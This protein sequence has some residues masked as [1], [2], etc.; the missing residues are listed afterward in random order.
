MPIYKNLDLCYTISEPIVL[1]F[2]KFGKLRGNH[3]EVIIMKQTSGKLSLKRVLITGG[4][5]TLGL[6]VLLAGMIACGKKNPPDTTATTANNGSDDPVIVAGGPYFS[7]SAIA[8]SEDG[9]WIYVGG[10]T[11]EAIYRYSAADYALNAVYRTDSPV[12]SLTVSG[13]KVYVGMGKLGGKLTV[14][15]SDLKEEGSVVVGHTPND[16]VISGTVAYVANRFSCTVS[17]VDL[18]TM[19]ETKEIA[20]SREPMAMTLVGNK[21]Y[22]A[23]HLPEDNAVADS[24]SPRISVIDT[25]KNEVVNSIALCNGAANVKDII[26]S[27]DGKTLYVSHSIARYTYP[28]TQLDGGW[29]YTNGI[30]VID[31][32]SDKASYAFLLDDVELGAGNPW[33]L[34]I[35]EKGTALYVAISGS[36]ELMKVDLSALAK[37]V[38]RVGTGNGLVASK[39]DIVDYIPFA[40]NCKSR[41]NLGG[42][43]VRSIA[44]SGD[45]V[46]CAQYFSG[47]ITAVGVS[48]SKMKVLDAFALGTQPEADTIRLGEALWYDSTICYQN[49]QS[50]ASCHPDG[51][52]DGY[53]WD[54]LNDGL[55]VSKQAKSMLYAMRTPPVMVTGI[56]PDGETAV[57]AG[58]K[59]ICFNADTQGIV[60]NINAYLM[61]MLPEQSP[62]LNDD[63]TLTE[64]ATRGKALFEQYGCVICH[65]APLYTDMKTHTSID[66]ENEPSWE[67]RDMDTSSL[68]EVWRTYP[69]GYF[70]GHTDMVE[71]VKYSVGKSGKTISDQDAQDLANFILSIGA[72]GEQYGAIQIRN[73]D[74]TYNK[75]KAGQN[76]VSLSV[77]KQATNAPDASVTLTL[78]DKDG[79]QLDTESKDIKNLS[80]GSYVTFDVDI[81]VP[82]DLSAGAYYVVS[83]QS[84]DGT[85]LATDLKIILY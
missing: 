21:L 23:C 76:L 18:A 17:V 43:G 85:A 15:S 83:F 50:C 2:Y 58:L 64:S 4:V 13:D 77:I 65:P 24:V 12:N 44:I 9:Q 72:E 71:Y 78:Y 68:V 49:W 82:A 60:E 74:G 75:L 1:P 51:R 11:D 32:A 73:A 16:V 56:R 63:G 35:N 6:G 41:L 47:T 27:P 52:A 48:G 46:Y 3:K 81:T 8:V 38:A 45:T 30:S 14:L 59:Y 42:E 61:A 10:T 34:A 84:A 39:K 80:Y 22:V 25:Q 55:G 33:G 20:V 62:Y 40:A 29:I 66:L 7:P 53:N 26:A 28:T 37:L 70:G 54:N 36:D 19:T 31:V 69:W 79:K 67:Y 57:A 5:L